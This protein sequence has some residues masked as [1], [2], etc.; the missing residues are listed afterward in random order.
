[1]LEANSL[2][3]R[4]KLKWVEIFSVKQSRT[5]NNKQDAILQKYYVSQSFIQV[6]IYSFS[7]SV[8]YTYNTRISY[9]CSVCICIC[10]TMFNIIKP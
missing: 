3:L 1:M 9:H 5:F 8:L 2:S 7:Y 6:F 10:S 4:R